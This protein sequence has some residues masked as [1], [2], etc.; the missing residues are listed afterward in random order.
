MVY[1]KKELNILSCGTGEND[2][3]FRPLQDYFNWKIFM[4]RVY[5]EVKSWLR[6]LSI[7]GDAGLL[8][9]ANTPRNDLLCRDRGLLSSGEQNLIGNKANLDVPF[10]RPCPASGTDVCSCLCAGCSFQH[11]LASVWLFW[12]CLL[13]GR[14]ELSDEACVVGFH[15]KAVTLGSVGVR[16]ALR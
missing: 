10:C 1:V 12:D 7:M 16:G 3:Y 15:T 11:P 13:S 6:T 2:L 14:E 9:R 4:E 8:G 5:I